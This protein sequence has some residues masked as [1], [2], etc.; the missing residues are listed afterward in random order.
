MKK[1]ILS[2]LLTLCMVLM[3]CPETVFADEHVYRVAGQSGLCGS[4]WAATDDNNRM[5]Y[6]EE[7]GRFEKVYTDV[8][9]NPITGYEYKIVVDGV[10]WIPGGLGSNQAVYVDDDNATVTIW[11]DE[12][13]G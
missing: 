3:L 13:T 12:E 11:Y 6:N 7:T 10:T 1:R 2:I 4:S 8:A 5:T 9:A